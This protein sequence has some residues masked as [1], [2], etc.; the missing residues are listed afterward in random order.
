VKGPEQPFLTMVRFFVLY[1]PFINRV[2]NKN[3]LFISY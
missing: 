3:P 1:R 2:T